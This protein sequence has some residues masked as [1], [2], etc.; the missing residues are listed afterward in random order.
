[1][2]KS[3]KPANPQYAVATAA[4][5]DIY[6]K[7][8]KAKKAYARCY[9]ATITL[10][11]IAHLVRFVRARDTFTRR[12]SLPRGWHLVPVQVAQSAIGHAIYFT[13]SPQSMFV[14]PRYSTGPISSLS[15][16]I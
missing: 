12:N 1:M 14:R 7:H 16:E 5:A 6:I 15:I 4:M 13:N 8:R 11:Y 9:K 3:M 2:L 10:K